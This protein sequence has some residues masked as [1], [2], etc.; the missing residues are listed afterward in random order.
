MLN[1]LKCKLK[2]IGLQL[3]YIGKVIVSKNMDSTWAD[4]TDEVAGIYA[5]TIA[6]LL[7]LITSNLATP[8]VLH[9]LSKFIVFYIHDAGQSKATIML[10][11]LPLRD[12]NIG[13]WVVEVKRLSA[14]LAEKEGSDA[15]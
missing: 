10:K 5:K 8:A 15:N 13:D 12:T 4:E 11:S 1:T 6:M 2:A 3:R 7:G 14:P 9:A